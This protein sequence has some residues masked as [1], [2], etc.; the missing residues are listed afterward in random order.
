MSNGLRWGVWD[1]IDRENKRTGRD[2]SPETVVVRVDDDRANSRYTIHVEHPSER[3][4]TRCFHRIERATVV[5]GVKSRLR[6]LDG[7]ERIEVIDEAGLRLTE[8]EL[9]PKTWIGVTGT[10]EVVVA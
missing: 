2:L 4:G 8:R 7:V 1:E 10:P 9:R 3:G 5:S 6:D